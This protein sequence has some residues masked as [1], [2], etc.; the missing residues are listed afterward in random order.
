MSIL[1]SLHVTSA[2]PNF[3][4]PLAIC[5]TKSMSA[6]SLDFGKKHKSIKHKIYKENLFE[7]IKQKNEEKTL[8]LIFNSTVL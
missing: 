2:N 7:L 8:K 3:L 4:P 6:Q 5:R 1:K